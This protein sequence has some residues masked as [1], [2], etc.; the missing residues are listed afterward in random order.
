MNVYQT[1]KPEKWEVW[2]FWKSSNSNTGVT[3]LP[4]TVFCIQGSQAGS[5]A[6]GKKIMEEICDFGDPDDLE[7]ELYEW[8][9]G[10][11]I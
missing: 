6:E 8:Y 3:K 7:Y 5:E 4:Q 2:H 1:L 11:Y 10:I 9:N